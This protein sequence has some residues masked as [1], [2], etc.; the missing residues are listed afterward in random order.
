MLVF[1]GN[2]WILYDISHLPDNWHE[3][4][5]YENLEFDFRTD[6]ANGLLWFS[7]TRDRNVHLSLKVKHPG[8]RFNSSPPG[9]KGRHFADDI[10]KRIFMK[11]KFC[12]L[13]PISLTFVSKG[14]T[15]DNPALV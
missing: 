10:F 7:G 5:F 2:T 9:Q 3:Q 13:I 8:R 4:N 15:D 1:D 11:E 14:S 6:N 12:I